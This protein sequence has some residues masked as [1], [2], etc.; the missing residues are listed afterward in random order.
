M[1][2]LS[3]FSSCN[4]EGQVADNLSQVLFTGRLFTKEDRRIFDVGA[5]E[6]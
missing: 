5:E 1:S 6:N 4:A 2:A 3:L